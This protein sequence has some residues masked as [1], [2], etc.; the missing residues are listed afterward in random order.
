MFG[1]RYKKIIFNSLL[2][3]DPACILNN[4]SCMNNYTIFKVF[5]GFQKHTKNETMQSVLL[6]CSFNVHD[7]YVKRHLHRN[8][9]ETLPG[10]NI[11]TFLPN[12][13]L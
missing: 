7:V 1:L 8:Y 11:R 3:G 4:K 12:L 6:S 2:S 13:S 10:R 9:Q 5:H